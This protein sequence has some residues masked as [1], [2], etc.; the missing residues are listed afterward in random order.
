MFAPILPHCAK[1]G[2]RSSRLLVFARSRVGM[3]ERREGAD[4]SPMEA[5]DTQFLIKKR[6]VAG[7]GLGRK[8]KVNQGKSKSERKRSMLSVI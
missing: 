8:T 5:V 6:T 7:P 4:L 3:K 1:D 2:R